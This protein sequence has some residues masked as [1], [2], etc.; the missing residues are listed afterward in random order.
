M[1][2]APLMGNLEL[3]LCAIG[4]AL[5]AAFVV[6][7]CAWAERRYNAKYWDKEKHMYRERRE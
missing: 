4:G 1:H 5:G 7:L 2:E 3:F 6:Y